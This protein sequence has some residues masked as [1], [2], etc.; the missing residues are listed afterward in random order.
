MIQDESVLDLLARPF[1]DVMTRETL[2]KRCLGMQIIW[3]IHNIYIIR[4]ILLITPI[5]VRLDYD[6]LNPKLERQL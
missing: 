6:V 3:V 1:C 5:Q 4:C 2:D